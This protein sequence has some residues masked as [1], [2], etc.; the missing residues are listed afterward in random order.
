MCLALAK[1]VEKVRGLSRENLVEG[2]DNTELIVHYLTILG[3]RELFGMA[4]I[5]LDL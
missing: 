4:R 3:E 1:V 2:G 5:R